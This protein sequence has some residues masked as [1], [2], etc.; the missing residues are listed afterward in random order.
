MEQ[1]DE[2]DFCI[3]PE[4]VVLLR[5]KDFFDDGGFQPMLIF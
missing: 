4:E 5:P 3:P 1:A 2:V